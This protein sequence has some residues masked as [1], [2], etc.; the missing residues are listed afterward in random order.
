MAMSNAKYEV[1][2]NET[3][4]K[5]VPFAV[6]EAYKTIRTNIMFLLAKN[7]GRK[8]SF[9]S[10]NAG[11]GKSTTSINV[12]VAFSQLGCKVLLVDADMR[13]SSIHK[14]LKLDNENGLSN[15]IAGFCTFEQAVKHFNQNLDI[16]TAGPIPPN[17]SELLGST[18]LDEIIAGIKGN[19]DYI[20][21]DTPPINVVSDALVLTPKTDG[22][23]LVVRDEITEHDSFECALASAR[24]A[25]INILGAVMNAADPAKGKNYKYRKY[26]YKKYNGYDSYNYKYEKKP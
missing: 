10:A 14:K 20:I 13:R 8:L 12:A 3:A 6:V 24:F 16:L 19:Y 15:L 11:E 21:F 1:S 4:S 26:R 9:S 18:Q 17:P 23:I 25:N 5:H 2:A 7:E 22:L